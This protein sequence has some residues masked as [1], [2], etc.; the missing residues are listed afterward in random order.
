M[1]TTSVLG[2][3]SSDHTIV[4]PAALGKIRLSSCPTIT[5]E[6]DTSA[7]SITRELGH[8]GPSCSTVKGTAAGEFA[9]QPL[10]LEVLWR[11]IKV[12]EL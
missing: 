7:S 6:L 1:P 2:R 8:S 3:E 4:I 11:P 12:V 10:A 5:L 9:A